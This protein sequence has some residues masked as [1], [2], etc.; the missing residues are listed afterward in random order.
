MGPQP[1]PTAKTSESKRGFWARL[2]SNAGD[3]VIEGVTTVMA[4]GIVALAHHL[5]E[6]W[7][8]KNERFFDYIP[9]RWVFVPHI[10]HC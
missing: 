5:I 8:G 6:L 4:I 2:G 10:S 1:N 3:M 9:V 7:I